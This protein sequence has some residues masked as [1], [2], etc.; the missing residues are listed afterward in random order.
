MQ[1]A[2]HV[3]RYLNDDSALGVLLNKSPIFDLLGYCDADWAAYPHSRKS[4]SDFVVFL[5]DTLLSWKSKKQTTISL[6]SAEAEYRSIRRLVAEL[7]WLSRLLHEL[8]LDSLTP[9]PIKCDN[10]AAIYIARNPV[11]HERTKHIEV[12]CHFIRHKLIE[13]VI[14]LTHVPTRDQLADLLTK[15]LTG[16]SHH[17]ILPELG[18]A[19]PSNFRGGVRADN[20]SAATAVTPYT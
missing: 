17:Y 12:D 18:V 1:A 2:I 3:L 7:S 13:G 9:I 20:S 11:F 15:P 16:V 5:G 8:T 10:L 6:S 14:T 19:S 4:V